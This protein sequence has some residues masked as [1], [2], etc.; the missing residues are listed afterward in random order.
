MFFILNNYHNFLKNSSI[1]IIFWLYNSANWALFKYKN[2]IKIYKE[3]RKNNTNSKNK[4][5]VAVKPVTSTLLYCVNTKQ[6]KFS[7]DI[8]G[9]VKDLRR[10]ACWSSGKRCPVLLILRWQCIRVSGLTRSFRGIY[11]INTDSSGWKDKRGV[12]HVSIFGIL[13]DVVNDM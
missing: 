2:R 12:V 7:M 1:S 9:I 13:T 8:K 6:L 11:H 5:S 3:L 4:R 10:K